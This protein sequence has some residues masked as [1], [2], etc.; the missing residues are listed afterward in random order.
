MLIEFSEFNSKLLLFFIFPVI[1]RI[2]YFI[3][4]YQIKEDNILFKTFR[5]FLSYNFSGIFLLI[6]KYNT[7][8]APKI[9]VQKTDLNSNEE[10]SESMENSNNIGQMEILRIK[11]EQKRKIKSTLYLLIL[12]LIGFFSYFGR[13]Y[14]SKDLDEKYH[15]SSHSIRTFFEIINYS[16]LSLLLIKQRLYLHHFISFGFITIILVIIFYI[17]FQYIKEKL[18]F[19]FIFFSISEF[20][21]ALYDVLI[22]RYMNIYF[23]NPYFIM[24]FVGI[25]ISVL[26]LLYDLITYYSYPKISGIIIGLRDNMN[27][28][29]AFFIFFADL[30]LEFFWNLGI[31]L[32]IFYFSPCHF[33]IPE[34]IS[35]FIFFIYKAI[36][37]EDE[38]YSDTINCIVISIC[39]FIILFFCLV[40]N[41][42]IILNFCKLDFNTRKRI[43]ERVTIE[44]IEI[45]TNEIVLRNSTLDESDEEA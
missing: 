6:F 39:Y 34:Y 1:R 42:V 5:Y 32:I 45:N 20:V 38:F 14:F 27:D 18:L 25:F 26:L 28:I 37:K 44:Y 11:L 30:I 13:Y 3:S 40:F 35:E 21:Y 9:K 15:Y 41:E 12:S 43:D 33:F 19:L 24:F 29:G 17:T 23:K 36:C 7:K 8:W 4:K 22:K 16:V 2:E 10:E 31:W